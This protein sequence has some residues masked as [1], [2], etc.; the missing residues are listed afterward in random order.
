MH[1]IRLSGATGR[2]EAGCKSG[3]Q[4][5]Q[6]DDGE[7]LIVDL[8]YLKQHALHT[9]ADEERSYQTQSGTDGGEQNTFSKDE[10]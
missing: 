6:A 9:A 7:D 5:H 4:Q 2:E 3:E 1:R 10:R 8:T